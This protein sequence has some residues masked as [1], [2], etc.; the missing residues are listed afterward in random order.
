MKLTFFGATDTVTGSRFLFEHDGRRW[1]VD[2]GLFQGGGDAAARNR[3]PLPFS[4]ASLDAVL[5]THAHIDHSGMLPA[6]IAGGYTGPIHTTSGTLELCNILLPD[7]AHLQQEH[8]SYLQRHGLE[9]VA[10]TPLY[11]PEDV[12]STL[13]AM[14][15][16]ALHR[17]F[18][19]APGISA[20]FRS[21]G[22]IL[23]A[24]SVYLEVDGLKIC[25]SGDIGRP[26]DPVMRA[27]EPFDGADY[28]LVESTYGGRRHSPED[29]AERLEKL[30]AE[31][32]AGGGTLVIPAFAVGRAQSILHLIAQATAAGRLPQVPVFLDSPMAINTTRLYCR[33]AQEHRLSEAQCEAMCGIAE[34]TRSVEQSKHIAAHSGPKIIVSASGMATGG[35]VLHHLKH[36]LADARN[37][38]LI[39]GYQAEK[40]LG[41]ELQRGIDVA[42]ILGA[43]IPVEARIETVDGLSAHADQRELTGWLHSAPPPRRTFIVH[44]EADSRTA[45]ADHLGAESGWASH[46]PAPGETVELD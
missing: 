44:G 46:C 13:A 24:A 5:V 33:H 23:G 20:H 42:P 40:T 4:P 8:Y 39:V 19:V 35:R 32:I 16:H 45:L 10:D 21:A 34:Y 38:V 27:P 3:A 37:A 25:V 12:D 18:N 36:Y 7:S 9:T 2:C 31:T 41:A 6:L 30:V 15:P 26:R 11:S 28:L 43:D 17:P 1:L 14:Q 22:H 29:P